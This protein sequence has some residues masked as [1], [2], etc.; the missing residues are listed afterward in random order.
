MALA[1]KRHKAATVKLT[2]PAISIVNVANPKPGVV[3]FDMGQNMVGVP[4]LSLPAIANQTVTVRF[5]EALDSNTF[6]FHGYRYVEV[7]GFDQSKKPKLSWV[8]GKVL[9]SNFTMNANFESSHAKLNKLSENVVWGLR[10]NF[11]DIPTDCPQLDERLG[12]TGDAQVFAAPSTY[13]ADVYGFWAAWL[14]SVREAQAQ[15]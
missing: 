9:H 11:L 14:Q 8:K 2:L 12:W 10:G 6:T 13:M 1:P 4:E 5:A 7:S 15:D 3:I